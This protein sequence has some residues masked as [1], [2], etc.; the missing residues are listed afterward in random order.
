MFFQGHAIK[1]YGAKF[2]LTKKIKS[3]ESQDA[4]WGLEATLKNRND[5]HMV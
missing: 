2:P 1:R 3:E 4:M 5:I